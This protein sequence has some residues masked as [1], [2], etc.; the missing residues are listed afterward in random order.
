MVIPLFSRDARRTDS[1]AETTVQIFGYQITKEVYRLVGDADQFLVVIKQFTEACSGD[2]SEILNLHTEI[3]F[4]IKN[5][6]AGV[7]NAIA[8]ASR[9]AVKLQP[10]LDEVFHVRN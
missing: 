6:L 4:A 1:Y 10:A 5:F 2:R 3:L 7:W 8:L 9:S